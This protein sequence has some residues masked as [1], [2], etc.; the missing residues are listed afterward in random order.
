MDPPV[1]NKWDGSAVKNA[2]DDATK[3]VMMTNIASVE[4]FRLIDGRLLIS[5]LAV[6][7]SL[8]ALLWDYLHPFPESRTV[9]MA[10]VFLYFVTSCVL[11]Y[12]TTFVERGIFATVL[13]QDPSGLDPSQSWSASS[14]IKKYDTWY[15]LTLKHRHGGSGKSREAHANL[16]IEKFFDTEGK[17]QYERLQKEVLKLHAQILAKME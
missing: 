8:T 13:E 16:A 15:K 3:S 7:F 9:L 5:S 2:L 1:I 17:L 10:C 6:G 11:T 4:C 12:H 14:T